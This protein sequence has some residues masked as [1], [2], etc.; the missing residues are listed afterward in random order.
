MDNN[1][2][3][4]ILEKIPPILNSGEDLD[5][6]FEDVLTILGEVVSFDC[7]Y[8][9]Y[10]NSTSANIRYK[11]LLNGCSLFEEKKIILEVEEAIKPALYNIE[12]LQFD[13]GDKIA[14][15]F[16]IKA[17]KQ[18]LLTKLLISETI[19][20]FVLL[21]RDDKFSPGDT[22]I[23]KI[24]CS[25]A[26]YSIK[27]SELSNVFKLQLKALQENIIDKSRAHATIKE[28]NEKILEADKV[29]SEFLANTSHELRTPL[30][31][32]IGFSEVLS[33]QLFGP[34]NDKQ[35]EYIRDIH[36]SG[37]HLLGM[38]NEILEISK[39][40]SKALKLTPSNFNLKISVTEVVNVV[41]PLAD[42]KKIHLNKKAKEDIE[43]YADY[44]KIQQIMYNLLSNA[45]KFTKE[46]GHIEIGY[47][48]SKNDVEIYVKD[49]GIGIDAKHHG[50]IF[51]KFV[52]LNNIYCK[53]ESSTGLGLTI[54]KELTELHGGK[55]SF[56]SSP[57]NGSTF[58]VSLPLKG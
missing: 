27:D 18:F 46:G 38:I 26:S 22:D 41:Q 4:K 44:Q 42:K 53:N 7:A 19:F 35:S 8:V 13:V 29:K 21:G 48:I 39:I 50:K 14:K 58:F 30:N 54:T 24:F 12:P 1:K 16:G 2:Y 45:I 25:L 33:K 3:K 55:I 11:K 20:G 56:H 15:S 34:L 17:K 40:E 49:D 51:G 6:C 36:V 28:Q 5:K 31:A 23:A 47:K 37:L 57:N 9:C 10:L 32:I 43:I 52:Q